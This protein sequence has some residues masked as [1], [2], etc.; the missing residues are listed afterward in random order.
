[1]H[2][3]QRRLTHQSRSEAL[4]AVPLIVTSQRDLSVPNFTI[5]YQ[6]HK[7]N[8]LGR[9]MVQK[10]PP[11]GFQAV[12]NSAAAAGSLTALFGLQPNIYNRFHLT[13]S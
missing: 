9:V 3:A 12:W 7:T 2:C 10:G 11:G 1:M 6:E 4:F 5:I 8:I 13:R